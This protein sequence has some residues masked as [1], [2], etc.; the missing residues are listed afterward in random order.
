[1]WQVYHGRIH[2][3]GLLLAD[4]RR[5]SGNLS[6]HHLHAGLE[7]SFQVNKALVKVSLLLTSDSGELLDLGL[8]RIERKNGGPNP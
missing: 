4:A 2:G 7:R 5:K 1:M 3:L 6:G 8:K